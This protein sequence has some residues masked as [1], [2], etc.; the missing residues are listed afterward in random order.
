MI[1][2]VN[3]GGDEVGLGQPLAR[4]EIMSAYPDR[5]LQRRVDGIIGPTVDPPSL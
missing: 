3:D 2:P 1:S 5:H 4:M